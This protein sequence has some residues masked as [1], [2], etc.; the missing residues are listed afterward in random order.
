MPWKR[1]NRLQLVQEN[2]ASTEVAEI[3]DELKAALGIGYVPLCFRSFAC[4]PKF[5]KAQWRAMKPLLATRQFFDLTA[6][7]R[8]EVYTYVHNYFKVPALAEGLT[9]SQ[10]APVVDLLCY[11]DSAELLLLSVQL[12]AF[13]GSIGHA[14]DARPADRVA[15]TPAPEF[16]DPETASA[17][18]RRVLEEMRHALDLP[19]SGDEQRALAH[20]PELLFAYWRALKP[21][22]QSIFHEQALFQMRES[23]WTCAQEIPVEIDMEYSRLIEYGV[24]PDEIAIL[25]R[26]TELLVQGV[27]TSLLNGTFAKIGVEGGNQAA[28]LQ[29][30]EERVA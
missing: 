8:A 10:A 17:P 15:T 14:I 9:P 5:L 2:D 12:L 18:V 3:F 21:A 25:T 28:D 13:E 29:Q 23:A 11:V 16:V 27:A 22:V 6:R 30:S 20:W 4:Y 1:G 7:L 24:D 26:L 19:F